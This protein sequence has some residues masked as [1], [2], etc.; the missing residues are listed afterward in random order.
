MAAQ[1]PQTTQKPSHGFLIVSLCVLIVSSALF[2]LFL[3]LD[4]TIEKTA[5]KVVETYT[6]KSFASRKQTYDQE[7]FIVSYSVNGKEYTKKTPHRSGYGEDYIPVYYYK[8]F[9]GFAW[10]YSKANANAIYCTIVM[11]L[12]LMTAGMAWSNS[13]KKRRAGAQAPVGK[14]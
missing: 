2:F 13:I 9:P 12:S 6:K 11:F 4:R 8:S 7:Y 3:K 1:P 10:C 5:G 14:K